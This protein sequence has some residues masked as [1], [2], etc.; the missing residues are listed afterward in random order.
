MP[1]PL[2]AFLMAHGDRNL[3]SAE[4]Q[5]VIDQVG[6]PACPHHPPAQRRTVNEGA[7]IGGKSTAQ[8]FGPN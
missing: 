2:P 6:V 1:P 8:F 7:G 5:S 4:A 3:P